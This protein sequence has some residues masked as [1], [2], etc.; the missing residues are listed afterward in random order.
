MRQSEISTDG[1]VLIRSAPRLGMSGLAK[2][3][4]LKREDHRLIRAGVWE[5]SPASLCLELET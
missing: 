4:E 2:G 3:D 5:T 1:V